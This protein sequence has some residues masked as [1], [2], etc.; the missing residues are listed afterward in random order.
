[1]TGRV[2]DFEIMGADWALIKLKTYFS[3]KSKFYK[4]NFSNIQMC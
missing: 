1:M 4:N 3:L 2:T